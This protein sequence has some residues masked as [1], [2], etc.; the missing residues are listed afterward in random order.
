M[1]QV[2]AAQ[3]GVGKHKA[4]SGDFPGLVVVPGRVKRAPGGRVIALGVV[5]PSGG[6]GGL[7]PLFFTLFPAP[8]HPAAGFS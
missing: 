3:V 5:V 6:I 4:D 7:G 1:I 8:R 2:N